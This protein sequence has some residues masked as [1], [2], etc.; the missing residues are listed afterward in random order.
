M[1]KRGTRSLPVNIGALLNIYHNRVRTSLREQHWG[2]SDIRNFE[3]EI[4]QWCWGEPL[5][6]YD[7]HD[8]RQRIADSSLHFLFR[9][10]WKVSWWT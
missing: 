3:Q 9:D 1:Q 4:R 7:G 2:D 5:A 8:T 6:L 10:C